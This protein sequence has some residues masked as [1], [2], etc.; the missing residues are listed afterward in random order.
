MVSGQWMLSILRRQLYSLPQKAIA[1]GIRT[2]D[3]ENAVL[4]LP[5]LFF[6]SASEPPCSSMMLPRYVKDSTFSR[7][8]CERL[9]I[10]QSFAIKSDWIAVLRPEF[11]DLAFPFVYVEAY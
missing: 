2:M 11:E 8:V 7:Q 3:V 9:Y 1:D 4:A 10:F 5:I 6:T